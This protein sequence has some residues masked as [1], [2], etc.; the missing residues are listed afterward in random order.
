MPRPHKCRKVFSNPDVIYF[1][2]VGLG[3]H[4]LQEVFL[5]LDEFE[6]VRLA[7]YEGFYQGIAAEK[8][9]VSRQTFGN[10]I[11]SAH[12]KLADFVINAKSLRIEGG[13]I[14]ISVEQDGFFLCKN[15]EYKFEVPC[16]NSKPENCPKCESD[17]I[18]LNAGNHRHLEEF[19]N[20]NR[21]QNNHGFQRQ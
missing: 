21:M 2:P 5:S 4:D 19:R 18:H 9:N 14:E 10:I 20:K 7:D 1:K 6:A 16:D 8:M 12:R 3:L 17:N 15:C 11:N 13:V